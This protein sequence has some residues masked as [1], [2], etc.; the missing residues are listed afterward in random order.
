MDSAVLNKQMLLVSMKN[1]WRLLPKPTEANRP[2][3]LEQQFELHKIILLLDNY[4]FQNSSLFL[5]SC[6]AC[7]DSVLC[8]FFGYPQLPPFLT[9][10]WCLSCGESG[11]QPRALTGYQPRCWL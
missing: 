3:A 4:F 6:K 5:L 8:P 7:S 10:A 1:G 11:Q 9:Q 2:L